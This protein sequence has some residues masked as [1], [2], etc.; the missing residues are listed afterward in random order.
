MDL[1]RVF[2][3]PG[4]G[5]AVARMAGAL[6]PGSVTLHREAGGGPAD[7]A[8][9]L[10]ACTPPIPGPA[11]DTV[12]AAL[13]GRT[14]RQVGPGMAAG[15]ASASIVAAFCAAVPRAGR[16]LDVDREGMASCRDGLAGG[17]LVGAAH[18]A[19]AGIAPCLTPAAGGLRPGPGG[20]AGTVCRGGRTVEPDSRTC[21]HPAPFANPYSNGATC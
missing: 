6:A 4:H 3:G 12:L 18:P 20:A 17:F 2:A 9:S 7:R 15:A 19:A 14:A 1:G 5:L 13:G 11:R 21:G 10:R 16:R 8:P